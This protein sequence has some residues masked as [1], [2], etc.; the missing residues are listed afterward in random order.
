M[1]KISV[2]I[3]V[4]N[5]EKYLRQCLD[6]VINQTLKDIEIICVNDGSTDGSLNILQEYANKD[7]RIKVISQENKGLS[8][9]RNVGIKSAKGEYIGFIDSDD[10][11]DKTFYENLYK[12]GKSNKADIVAG[13]IIKEKGTCSRR[14]TNY[15]IP[16]RSNNVDE[17]FR[18]LKIPKFNYVW[19]KIYN[20][21]QLIKSNILFEE[22]IKYEDVEFTHKV[23]FYLNRV[24]I[25]PKSN[26]HYRINQNGIC[27]N[28]SSSSYDYK[29]AFNKSLQFILKHKINVNIPQKNIDV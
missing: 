7:K 21:E 15:H 5:V 4:Y 13:N 22:N 6:S 18:L 1:A 2:I 12:A 23:A 14:I 10:W 24:V 17:K 28:S 16:Y 27:Q 19:N 9:A 3:P 26:Y 25:Q 20:R 29:N 11:I 8:G